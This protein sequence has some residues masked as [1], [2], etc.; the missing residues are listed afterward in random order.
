MRSY[1]IWRLDDITPTMNWDA[2]YQYMDL[3][4]HYNVVP[5]L[6]VVPDNRDVKLMCHQEKLDFW[7]ILRKY[8][9]SNL[10][11]IAQHGYQHLYCTESI[12]LLKK[13]FGFKQ[14]SE[15]AGL[16][17]DEQYEKINNGR[18]ILNSKGLNTSYWMAPNHSFDE[19]TLKVLKA[20]GFSA[21]TDGIGLFP[22]NQYELSFVP[23]QLWRPRNLPIGIW[24]ICLHINHETFESIERVKRHLNKFSSNIKFS[25]ALSFKQN[26]MRSAVN[27]AFMAG[28]FLARKMGI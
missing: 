3:F 15:F 28:Y 8:Y 20:L 6:G 19:T 10:V 12:G 16:G 14:G 22:Y 17:Y 2:F 1:Y 9:Y 24:T 13:C 23:Q 27:R 7:D 26:I 11:E 25:D 18:I 21:V 4:K 5:L